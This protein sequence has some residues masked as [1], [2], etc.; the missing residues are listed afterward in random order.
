MNE[1][2]FKN[3]A[4]AY[5]MKCVEPTLPQGKYSD[6]TL[7]FNYFSKNKNRKINCTSVTDL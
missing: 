3:K 2:P 1:N 4:Y 6:Y 7:V 5:Y